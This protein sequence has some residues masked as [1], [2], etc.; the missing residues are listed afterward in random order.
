MVWR[1]GLDIHR[2]I[3]RSK[4]QFDF[5]TCSKDEGYFDNEIKDLGGAIYFG[6]S[7]EFS[8]C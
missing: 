3:D 1:A 4:I 7:L 2:N 8:N 6:E 5:Y